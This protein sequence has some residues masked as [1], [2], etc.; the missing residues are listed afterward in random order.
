MAGG[1]RVAPLG[2]A[3]PTRHQVRGFLQQTFGALA[4]INPESFERVLNRAFC[5]SLLSYT[6]TNE[7]AQEPVTRTVT[8][9]CV[10]GVIFYARCCQP[11]SGVTQVWS[12][13]TLGWLAS[14]AFRVFVHAGHEQFLRTLFEEL[15]TRP[16]PWTI[17]PSDFGPLAEGVSNATG[18]PRYRR[19]LNATRTWCYFDPAEIAEYVEIRGMHQEIDSHVPFL[20]IPA[21]GLDTEEDL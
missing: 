11:G 19:R 18:Y 7:W 4:P 3:G 8:P 9:V 21:A 5:M 14:G 6:F 1:D 10:Y 12:I 20:P 15:Y 17:S 2:P 16:P 13:F